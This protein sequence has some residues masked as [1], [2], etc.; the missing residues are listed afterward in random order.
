MENR[1]ARERKWR[2]S[3][4]EPD[5]QKQSG[6]SYQ[7]QGKRPRGP[8]HAD[9]HRSAANPANKTAEAPNYW[10]VQGAGLNPTSY[11]GYGP[12]GYRRS[13]EGILEDIRD[14]LTQ[15]AEIDSDNIEVNVTSGTV[16]LTGRVED[17]RI[18]RLVEANVE[19]IPGVV[20]VV[21]ELRLR[22]AP[23]REELAAENVAKEMAEKF[24]GGPTPSG[25][26]GY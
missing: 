13:D 5:S 11:S 18:Q 21:D 12:H 1:K 14:R 10:S 2:R 22:Q 9:H 26:A 20:D 19:M 6:D 7:Q 3:A 16:T 17:R 4:D 8:R 24:P 23:T 15:H 25:N